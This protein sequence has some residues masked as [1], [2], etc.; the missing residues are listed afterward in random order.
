MKLFQKLKSWHPELLIPLLSLVVGIL[1]MAFGEAAVTQAALPSLMPQAFLGEYSRDEV[2]WLPLEEDSPIS[3]LEGD[4]YL[5]GSF[6]LP[7]HEKALISYYSNHIG[8]EIRI[9]GRLHSRDIQLDLPVYGIDLQPSMCGRSWQSWYFEDALP[10]DSLIEIHLTNPHRFGNASA[11]RDFL[12]TL[13]AS[14]NGLDLLSIALQEYSR[15]FTAFGV[16]LIIAALLL[17]GGSC[18]AFVLRIQVGSKLTKLGLLS[19]FAGGYFLFDAINLSL[20]SELNVVNT[21]GHQVCMMLSVYLLGLLAGEFLT[22][23]RRKAA[24]LGLWL[25]GALNTG[26]ILL[27]AFGAVL[28]YDTLFWWVAGQML[29]CPVLILCF[30]LEYRSGDRNGHLLFYPVLFACLLIDCTGVTRALYS[31][32]NLTKAGFLLYYIHTFFLASKNIIL[33]HK[34]SVRAR[35]LEQELEE[36]RISVMLSQI[37]P[38]FLY[39][40][41]GTIRGLCREDPEQ[42]WKAL[43]DFS[44]YLRGNMNALSS[45]KAIPFDRE[46][47]HVET[48]LQLEKMRLGSKLSIIYDIQATDFFLPPLTLQPLVENAVKH[49]IFYKK[50]GGTV[51]LH[52]RRENGRIHLTVQDDGLGF[53]PGRQ[54]N[55]KPDSLGLSN[56]RNRVEKMLGGRLQVQSQPGQGTTVTVEFPDTAGEGEKLC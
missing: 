10:Q 16:L 55:R 53:D 21:G 17:L 23:S 6:S 48:Y 45:S 37:H 4:L 44:N 54:D 28:I 30:L 18:A 24:D 11:Y 13:C 32:G 12:N 47:Q 7:I 2:H 1:A 31:L 35:K 42:A 5:R 19:A 27:S 29:L 25:S 14:P 38:H 49:G 50:E 9:D 41:L 39:N 33:D 20:W 56:V 3:A 8:A 26:I 40:V 46:L 36:S 34:A 15:P 52:A 51:I 43:G 22:G